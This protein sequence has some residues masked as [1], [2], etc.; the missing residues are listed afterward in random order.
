MYLVSNV[1]QAKNQN[2][3]SAAKFPDLSKAFNTL[4]HTTLLK[5]TGLIGTERSNAWFENYLKNRLLVTKLTTV[6]NKI[7][8][9]DTYNIT[10][11]TAQG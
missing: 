1:L 8:K 9:S 7:V 2:K 5:K 10:Y 11:G 6:D 4:D 3:H